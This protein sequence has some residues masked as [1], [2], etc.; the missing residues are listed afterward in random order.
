MNKWQME[1][2]P[3][4]V[5][6]LRTIKR[7]PTVNSILLN[8]GELERASP[9]QFAMIWVPGVDEIPMS[10]TMDPETGSAEF[11]VKS[12]G[13]ATNTL[14]NLHPGD[15]IGVRG[16]YGTMFKLEKKD[17]KLLIVA[18][19]TGIAPLRWLIREE[20]EKRDLTV[21]IGAKTK[22]E[23]LFLEEL[24]GLDIRLWAATDD[25]TEGYH[26]PAAELAERQILKD[27]F[28]L[29]L[30]CGPESMISR[31]IEMACSHRL[32]L[33]ASLERI[34]KCGIGICGSCE[35]A[36]YRVCKEG[37]VFNL[38]KLLEMMGELGKIRRDHSGRKIPVEVSNQQ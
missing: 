27:D 19:G 35:I 32:K 25:G 36:G 26:G 37:P 8:D 21:I 17:R 4:I 1:D 33:Q 13:E 3:R 38:P 14:N 23:L 6:I 24:K 31:L 18:G 16:P 34:M 2:R 22:E 12:V 29:I 5:R 20:S 11:V 15:P 30:C 10:I 28:N 9:G 7:S